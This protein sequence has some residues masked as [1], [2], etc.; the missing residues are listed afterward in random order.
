MMKKHVL[1]LSLIS[2]MIGGV[3][4]PSLLTLLIPYQVSPFSGVA[5]SENRWDLSFPVETLKTTS[6]SNPKRQITDSTTPRPPGTPHASIDILGDDIFHLTAMDESWPGSGSAGDPYIIENYDIS[7]T[8]PLPEGY[9]CISIRNCWDVHFIIRGCLLEGATQSGYAG[10]YLQNTR[11]GQIQDNVIQN[12][13]FGIYIGTAVGFIAGQS[14]F[15]TIENNHIESNSNDGIHLWNITQTNIL[16][17]TIRDNINGI[18]VTST[19]HSTAEDNIC[20][21]NDN[22]GIGLY[23][24]DNIILENNTCTS[25]GNDGIHLDFSHANQI[26]QNNCTENPGNGI[27]LEFSNANDLHQDFCMLN[28]LNGINLYFSNANTLQNETSKLNQ[29]H[30]LSLVHSHNLEITNAICDQNEYSGIYLLFSDN[31]HISQSVCTLNR[32][33]VQISHSA[34]NTVTNC[35]CNQNTDYGIGVFTASKTGNEIIWNDFSSNDL[36]N[37]YDSSNGTR[38]EYNYYSDYTGT[39]TD[40]DGYGNDPYLLPGYA[41]NQDPHPLINPIHR[42]PGLGETPVFLATSWSLVLVFMMVFCIITALF[43]FSWFGKLS[44]RG[45]YQ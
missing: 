24:V 10:I 25:N 15:H 32:G 45:I 1:T 14:G 44:K 29:Y 9:G 20:E 33:G 11:Y 8:P 4:I 23:S 19:N 12:N 13:N 37:A 30:G 22:D 41:A 42:Q 2:L 40:N 21:L 27:N 17:N 43:G 38:F 26:V 36:E 31:V 34:M 28:Q 7:V 18:Y 39:D 6:E 3:I 35:S 5:I 16:G